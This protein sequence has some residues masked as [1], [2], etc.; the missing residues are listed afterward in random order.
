MSV[1]VEFVSIN[2]QDHDHKERKR[3]SQQPGQTRV[4]QLQACGATAPVALLPGPCTRVRVFGH[5]PTGG[6]H[7]WILKTMMSRSQTNM[8]SMQRHSGHGGGIITLFQ[9]A[10][11]AHRAGVEHKERGVQ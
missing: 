10:S 5:G 11:H 4:L 2:L 6:G 8:R 3:H 7:A 9:K 1:H